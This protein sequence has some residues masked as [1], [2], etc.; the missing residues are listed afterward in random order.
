LRTVIVTDSY[1]K[2]VGFLKVIRRNN[3]PD[4]F[5]IKNL[6]ILL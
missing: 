1:V 5:V 3:M 6:I 4:K 2:N